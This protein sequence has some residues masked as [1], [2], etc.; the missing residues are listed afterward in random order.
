MSFWLLVLAS[1]LWGIFAFVCG[2]AFGVLA[3]ISYSRI[4]EKWKK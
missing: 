2:Y 3:E 1:V 4:S